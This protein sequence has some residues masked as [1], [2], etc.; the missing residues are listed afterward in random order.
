[1]NECVLLFFS[2]CNNHFSSIPNNLN[3]QLFYL[4]TIEIHSISSLLSKFT[5]ILKTNNL[6]PISESS[7][8]QNPINSLFH[9]SPFL[10]IL[11][12]SFCQIQLNETPSIRRFPDF[13]P[14]LRDSFRSHYLSHVRTFL[15][16]NSQ[17]RNLVPFALIL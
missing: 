6:I 13:W 14:I 17:C 2:T 9:S 11:N 4:L 16:W 12:P 8:H 15:L 1:M 10:H 5:N 3:N 7:Y